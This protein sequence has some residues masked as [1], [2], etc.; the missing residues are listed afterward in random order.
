MHHQNLVANTIASDIIRSD[1]KIPS[2]PAS[3]QQL[4]AIS[5]KPLDKIDIKGLEKLIQKDPVLFAQ[6]LKLANSSYYG[7]GR[8]TVGLHDAI[9]RIGLAD[10]ISSLYLYLFK[11]AL[12]TF[13][14]I[15]GVS[16]KDYWDESWACAIANRR[17]GDS[18]L[19][20][21]SLP[22]DLYIAGLL[23]GIGKL[24]LAVYDP[25][26]FY[27]CIKIARGSG[28]SLDDVELGIFGTTDSLVAHKVLESWNLPSNICAAVGYHKYPEFAAD[29]KYREIAAITQ[30]AT[31]VVKILR[32]LADEASS[33]VDDSKKGE[34]EGD[35]SIVSNKVDSDID[36]SELSNTFIVQ[37]K[38]SLLAQGIYQQKIVKEISEILQQQSILMQ[39][40]EEA[41][42]NQ[43]KNLNVDAKDRTKE[44]SKRAVASSPT[45]QKRGIMAWIRS[46]FGG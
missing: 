21:E 7:I 23:H 11:N 15:K 20:V 40:K 32:N 14:Q 26:K 38:I 25:K 2:L 10:T 35:S 22:G 29:T 19:L 6:I 28:Q 37:N 42:T 31:V 18:R 36:I 17:L 45:A 30:F 5:Q 1:V 8:E 43:D 27:E 34:K 12:P 44:Y 33:K 9:M 13:P 41:N 46:L 39:D 24:I 4:L 16:D 3:A